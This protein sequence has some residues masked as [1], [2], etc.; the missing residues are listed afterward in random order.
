MSDG[1]LVRQAL[2]GRTEAFAEL[3]RRWAGRVTALCHAKIGRG[4]MAEDLAQESLLRA[5]RTLASLTEPE[6]FGPWLC[7]IAQHVCL[8]WLKSK[9]RTQ[10]P[11][12]ALQPGLEPEAIGT[13]PA[14]CA[15]E[16]ED[17]VRRLLSEVEALP[18]D[19]REVLM[20]YYYQDVTYQ[21]VARLLGV[22][23]ATVN[24][25]L[26]KA[27]AMLRERLGRVRR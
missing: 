9:Q 17:E 15:L 25:R 19:Y 13:T 14:D 24:A 3:V 8:D 1:E 6:K 4:D 21:D 5:Y 11:L 12:S 23:A 26:T 18:E 20:L 10:I 22:S 7:A 16:F 2:A 27:R